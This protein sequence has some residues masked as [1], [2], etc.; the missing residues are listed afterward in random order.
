MSTSAPKR[1]RLLDATSDDG[2]ET[3]EEDDSHKQHK[4]SSSSSSSSSSVH[5]Q[6]QRYEDDESDDGGHDQQDDGGME[7]SGINDEVSCK[8]PSPRSETHS[9]VKEASW[10][11]LSCD[12]IS[13]L[14]IV[15]STTAI[16]TP[17]VFTEQRALIPNIPAACKML[18]PLRQL[19]L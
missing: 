11:S 9:T 10:G 17:C 7:S 2:I 6:Q 13:L 19:C 12:V 3:I 15:G 18:Q 4:S 5:K 16:N 8:R 1:K 14:R